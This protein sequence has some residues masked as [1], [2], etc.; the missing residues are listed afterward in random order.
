MDDKVMVVDDNSANLKLASDILDLEG[1][2]VCRC[3]DAESAIIALNEFYPRLILMDVA[4]P[5]MDGI[6]LMRK[7]KTDPK[8][9]KITIVA[10]TAFAMKDDKDRLLSEGFDG[11]ITKPIEMKSFLKQVQFY[12]KL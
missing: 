2:E 5:G 10:L 3:Q 1:Y 11:Y 8:T 7:L 12:L 6:Q 4:L 9:N